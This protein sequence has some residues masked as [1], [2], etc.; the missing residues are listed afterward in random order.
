MTTGRIVREGRSRPRRLHGP[1]FD[2]RPKTICVYTYRQLVIF[3]TLRRY[4]RR[5]QAFVQFRPTTQVL[6]PS[7]AG[8]FLMTVKDPNG[9]NVTFV[10]SV[11]YDQ[12]AGCRYTTLRR[13]NINHGGLL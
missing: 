8:R 11:T 7:G 4:Y 5:G 3:I 12:F 6:P 1:N 10:K 2:I 13:N 9:H